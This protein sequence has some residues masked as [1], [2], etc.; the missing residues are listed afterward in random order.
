MELFS[1]RT[2]VKLIT[3]GVKDADK[4]V[5]PA[6]MARAKIS[7]SI[8]SVFEKGEIGWKLEISLKR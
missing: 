3:T 7:P 5:N 2:G 4:A 1:R 6:G 8:K